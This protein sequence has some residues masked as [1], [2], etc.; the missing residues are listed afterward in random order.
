MQ[1][2][3][4]IDTPLQIWD[5]TSAFIIKTETIDFNGDNK[6]DYFVLF[7]NPSWHSSSTKPFAFELWYTSSFKVVKR[8]QISV[9]LDYDFRW[10]INLDNDPEPEIVSARGF[11][12]G[13]T[14][15][16]SDQNPSDWSEKLTFS[17]NP[18]LIDPTDPWEVHYWGY[19]KD[20]T[21]IMTKNDGGLIKIRCS[22]EHKVYRDSEHY[23]PDWQQQHQLPVIFFTGK[24]KKRYRKDYRIR[25]IQWLSFQEII[26]KAR[27]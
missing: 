2:P 18:I 22:F 13:V 8:V 7:R 12:D 17:F 5:T 19:T 26:E 25:K 4:E 15:A 1:S 14:Y 11:S 23:V 6:L 24:P 20:I 9:V 10:F 21:N 16:I 3:Q 27:R